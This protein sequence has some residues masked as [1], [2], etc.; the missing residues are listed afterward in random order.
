MCSSDFIRFH[1][2]SCNVWQF[3]SLEDLLILP[4]AAHDTAGESQPGLNRNTPP[5]PGRH[6]HPDAIDAQ[7][8]QPK[9]A[10]KRLRRA[11]NATENRRKRTKTCLAQ[12]PALPLPRTLGRSG[13]GRFVGLL[14]RLAVPGPRPALLGERPRRQG[15]KG[16]RSRFLI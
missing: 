7:K 5:T 2:F 4:R 13:A 10:R 15:I 9:S 12:L 11:Q 8:S 3:P 16:N 1:V 6:P 14:R